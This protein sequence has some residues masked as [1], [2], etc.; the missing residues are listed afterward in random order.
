[1]ESTGESERKRRMQISSISSPG[2]RN[3]FSEDKK[4]PLF[5]VT[6]SILVVI[7]R[8]PLFMEITVFF[9]TSMIISDEY[10]ADMINWLT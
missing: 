5:F 3:S 8:N 6:M 10:I 9:F 2:K 7:D 4:V 1:M